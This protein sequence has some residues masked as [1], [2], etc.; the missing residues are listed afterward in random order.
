MIHP[1]RRDFSRWSSRN[2]SLQTKKAN[3]SLPVRVVSSTPRH[4]NG[5]KNKEATTTKRNPFVIN[6]LTHFLTFLLWIIHRTV[7]A[8]GVIP[9]TIVD[10]EC[11]E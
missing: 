11:C 4:K 3:C 5:E 8:E 6:K 2:T 7:C 1:Q 9:V 10:C